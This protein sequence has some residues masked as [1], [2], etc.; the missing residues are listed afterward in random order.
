M[1]QSKFSVP[2]AAGNSKRVQS[3]F[4]T[5]L[6]QFPLGLFAHSSLPELVFLIHSPP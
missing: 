4:L 5:P 2:E 3:L 1:N 6:P